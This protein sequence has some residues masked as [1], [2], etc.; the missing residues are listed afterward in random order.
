MLQKIKLKE[1]QF[2][3]KSILPDLYITAAGDH[4]T[5]A[6]WWQK[7]LAMIEDH[8]QSNAAKIIRQC[9][10]QLDEYL[11]GERKIFQLPLSAKGTDFQREVWSAL[12]E[13]PYGDTKSYSDIGDRIKRPK[14]VRAIGTANG[15][16]PISII[17]PCHRVIGKDGTLTGYAGGLKA[18]KILLELELRS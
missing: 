14:A 15:R 5:G 7:N 17:I 11:R 4:I 10:A 3:Y 9:G 1:I 8:D 18:K 13:I 2:I 6:Y 12:Q 16:N